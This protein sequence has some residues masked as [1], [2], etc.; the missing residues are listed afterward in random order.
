MDLKLC[1]TLPIKKNIKITPLIRTLNVNTSTE[2]YDAFTT[3]FN[4]ESRNKIN[5][6]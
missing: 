1:V 2:F 6:E 5:R 3:A 4:I